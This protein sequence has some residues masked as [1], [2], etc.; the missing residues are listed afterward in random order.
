MGNLTLDGKEKAWGPGYTSTFE[1]IN[2]LGLLYYKLGRYDK[3]E[4]M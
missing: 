3:A 2:N 4:K 1:T